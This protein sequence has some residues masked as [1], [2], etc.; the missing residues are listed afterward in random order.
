MK[1]YDAQTQLPLETPDLEAGYL[2]DGSIVTGY[3]LEVMPGTV[4]EVRKNGLRR[5]VAEVEPC[6]WYYRHTQEEQAEEQEVSAFD[7]LEAQLTY[8][9]MMTDT[10]LEE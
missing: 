9:A 7:R 4:T 1:I 5:R 10:L 3:S 8:T 2:V 6:Q